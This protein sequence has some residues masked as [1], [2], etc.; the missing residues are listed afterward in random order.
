MKL[1]L[2][3]KTVTV[4]SLR[5][6]RWKLRFNK[7]Y[8]FEVRAKHK[9]YTFIEDDIYLQLGYISHFNSESDGLISITVAKNQQ[10]LDNYLLNLK[11]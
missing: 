5:Y 10:E 7:V 1:F 4:S 3:S 11:L 6:I 2:K 8:T 9:D